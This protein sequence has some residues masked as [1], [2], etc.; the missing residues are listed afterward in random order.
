MKAGLKI[1]LKWI[2]YALGIMILYGLVQ[3]YPAVGYMC[4]AAWAAYVVQL[5]V[6]D[7]VR[8]VLWEELRE[9]RSQVA[10]TRSDTEIID[11]KV[12]AILADALDQRR[13]RQ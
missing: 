1:A 8:E 10:A 2:G 13:A 12:S 7:S 6:K 4:A 5:I 9:M 11:R 3:E